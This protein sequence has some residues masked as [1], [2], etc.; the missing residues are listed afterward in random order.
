MSLPDLSLDGNRQLGAGKVF[1]KPHGQ[2]GLIALNETPNFTTTANV[3]NT[4]LQSVDSKVGYKLEDITTQRDLMIAF[5]VREIDYETL[6]M[7]YF[8]DSEELDVS[9]GAVGA[10]IDVELGKTFELFD[11][12]SGNLTR[13]R[14]LSAFTITG[15]DEGEDYFVDLDRGLVYFPLNSSLEG[16]TAWTGTAVADTRTILK[17]GNAN[18]LEGALYY[19]A[20]NTV[21][22]NWDL[23]FPNVSLR[24]DGPMDFKDRATFTEV[25]FS[26]SVKADEQG[27]QVYVLEV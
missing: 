3:T 19:I 8:A 27:N 26:A 4:E 7:F 18:P 10:D 11:D 5:Q 9:S 15:A 22:A 20:N 17:G 6:A 16:S 14:R 12:D 1:F 2:D 21:G 23:E 13:I 25:P 24:P